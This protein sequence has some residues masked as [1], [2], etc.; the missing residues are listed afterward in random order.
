MYSAE[1]SGTYPT[2]KEV[3]C[4]C[5]EGLD[6]TC[7]DYCVWWGFASIR[8]N[9]EMHE[10]LSEMPRTDISCQRVDGPFR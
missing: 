3:S 10:K 5:L 2:L 6:V 8:G 9:D 7:A 1:N 4:L